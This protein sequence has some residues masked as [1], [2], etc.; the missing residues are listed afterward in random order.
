MGDP[1]A[2]VSKVVMGLVVVT[3]LI[4]ALGWGVKRLGLAG[5]NG[6]KNMRVISSLAVGGR[7]RV[8]LIDVAG[9]KIL[10]GIAPTESTIYKAYMPTLMMYPRHR[11]ARLVRL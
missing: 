6:Q 4:F 8:V 10:L 9:E 3:A 11:H 1:A 5:L 7:E 2:V